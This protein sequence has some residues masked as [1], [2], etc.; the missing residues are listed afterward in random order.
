MNLLKLILITFPKWSERRIF[1]NSWRMAIGKGCRMFQTQAFWPQVSNPDILTPNFHLG[2]FFYSF[3]K[4]FGLENKTLHNS[5]SVLS[6]DSLNPSVCP[7]FFKNEFNFYNKIS[8]IYPLRTKK[9]PSPSYLPCQCLEIWKTPLRKQYLD[10]F[11][12]TDTAKNN[13]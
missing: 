7:G 2:W 5:N 11:L 8:Y 6:P 4:R 10:W 13:C 1:W 12:G 3:Q 9:D